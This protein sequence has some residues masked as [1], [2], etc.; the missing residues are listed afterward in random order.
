[1]VMSSPVSERGEFQSTLS[2]RRATAVLN[3]Y[4]ALL[5]QFQSTLSMRRATLADIVSENGQYD[6][7]PRSP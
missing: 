4:G 3:R 6:F 5:I 2:M 1:M 7:N